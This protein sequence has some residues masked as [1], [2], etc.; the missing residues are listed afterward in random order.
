MLIQVLTPV[1]SLMY[2]TPENEPLRKPYRALDTAVASCSERKSEVS[3]DSLLML[4]D[5]MSVEEF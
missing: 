4:E 5:N 1:F 3:P 2:D